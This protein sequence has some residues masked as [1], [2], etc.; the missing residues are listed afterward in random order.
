MLRAKVGSRLYNVNEAIKLGEIAIESLKQVQS[1][2][3][4]ASGWGVF[5]IFKGKTITTMI[6]RSN[7]NKARRQSEKADLAIRKFNN[8]MI[9]LNKDLSVGYRYKRTFFL[10]DYFDNK[11]FDSVIQMQIHSNKKRCKHAINELQKQVYFLQK[12]K[13]KLMNE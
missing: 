1:Y 5:D 10:L 11:L 6:K 2:L 8:I 12:E 7:L 9:D 13:K 4:T 3:N